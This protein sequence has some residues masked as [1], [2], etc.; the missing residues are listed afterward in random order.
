[1]KGAE[2]QFVVLRNSAFYLVALW[3]LGSC[4]RQERTAEKPAP[5][6]RAPETSAASALERNNA[7]APQPANSDP[8]S[9]S[10]NEVDL[11]VVADKLD[12]PCGVAV[13]PGTDH[14]FV[15]MKERI[16]RLAPGEPN[17]TFDFLTDFPTDS[18]GKGPTYEFGPLGIAFLNDATLV[19][20]GGGN[21]DG[22]DLVSV[23]GAPAAPPTES[24]AA[25]HDQAKYTTGPIPRG[26]DSKR[27]EGNFHGVAI[28]G[29]A[30]FVTCNG[31]DTKG[32]I[33]KIEFDGDK[34]GP[35]VPFISSKV[36]TGVDGPAGAVIAPSGKLLVSQLGELNEHPDSLLTFYD[37]ASGALLQKLETG[38]CDV[39]AVAYSPKTGALYALDFAWAKPSAGGLFRL[40]IRGEKV[41]AKRLARIDKPTAMAFAADGTLYIAALGAAEKGAAEISGKIFRA[42]GL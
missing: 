13:Q 25:K 21:Q 42:D 11:L 37:P 7:N 17:A 1:M 5:E 28:D 22:E 12:N 41:R 29:S 3:V 6:L 34:P 19:V 32:W 14:V 4:D 8:P 33:G 15:S 23:Y 16:I 30:A 40:E 10:A 18:Y 35:L 9:D 24:T 20:G 27:G 31:D 36:L 39:T 38:L 2:M 26:A